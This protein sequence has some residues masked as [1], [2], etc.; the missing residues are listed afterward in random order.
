[1]EEA[2]RRWRQGAVHLARLM[3]ER[4]AR[5]LA[6]IIAADTPLV[7]AATPY[8]TADALID[9]VLQLA[10]RR[11][12]FGGGQPPRSRAA[13]DEAVDGGRARLHEAVAH[14]SASA[15]T[16]FAQAR[17]VR[18]CLD[19][20]RA[21]SHAALAQETQRHLCRLFDGE[22]ISYVSDEWNR[23]LPRYLKAEER[24]WQRLLARG[25][26]APGVLKELLEWTLRLQRLASQV[27][28][29]GR[30]I[31]LIDELR[32]G[33]EEYRV[34]LYAQELKTLGPISAARLGARAAEI[35]EW[36]TR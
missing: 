17:A 23:Q 4:Q 15:A 9:G 25:Q 21:R 14:V 8:L 36:I 12:C 19:D 35:E 13:F 28:A 6:K 30:W 3:L 31:P 20:P 16:G 29:E 7:L 18:R 10:F 26:E 32:T 34:S 2:D 24:R 27:A 33:I 22:T 11:A 1:V 5:D